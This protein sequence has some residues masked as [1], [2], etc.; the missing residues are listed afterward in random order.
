LLLFRISLA[1]LNNK[2][3]IIISILIKKTVLISKNSMFLDTSLETPQA[4][5]I[6][7]DNNSLNLV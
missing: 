5:I 6:S 1:I 2:N 3:S 7:I 4:N